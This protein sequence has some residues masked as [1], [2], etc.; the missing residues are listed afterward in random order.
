MR[1]TIDIL[2]LL[3]I[4]VACAPSSELRLKAGDCV[5]ETDKQYASFAANDGIFFKVTKIGSGKLHLQRWYNN[6][7]YYLKQRPADYFNETKRFSYHKAT[8]PGVNDPTKRRG[9]NETLK[10]IKF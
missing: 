5:Q 4:V 9:L 3:F 6:G 2:F 7:W 8:C 1:K 10:S